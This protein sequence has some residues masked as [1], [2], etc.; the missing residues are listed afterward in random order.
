MDKQKFVSQRHEDGSITIGSGQQLTIANAAEFAT[1]IRAALATA[2][3]V[4]VEFA[5]EVEVD[6]TTVQ[7][8][9]SAC[10][11][12]VAEGKALVPQGPGLGA[13]RQ[14]IIAAGAER[15]GPCRHNHNNPCTWFGGTHS[16][17]K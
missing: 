15:P 10:K 5:L 4:A 14:V 17:P 6:V 11:S 1:C 7:T 12:A 2:P 3:R 8:L 16:W 9:C 13:L